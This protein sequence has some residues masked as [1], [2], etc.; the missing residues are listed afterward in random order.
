[1]DSSHIPRWIGKE[2]AASFR[3]TAKD[4]WESAKPAALRLIYPTTDSVRNSLE[5]WVGGTAL[6]HHYK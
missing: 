4:D 1:M 6:P 2:L 5:G 3:A